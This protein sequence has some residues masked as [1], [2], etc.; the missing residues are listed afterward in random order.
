MECDQS[1]NLCDVG[2]GRI[3]LLYEHED[4]NIPNH[5]LSLPHHDP[6]HRKFR[7]APMLPKPSCK[8]D[9]SITW[10]SRSDDN[11]DIVMKRLNDF[12]EQTKPVI[13]FFEEHNRLIRFVPHQGVDDLPHLVNLMTERIKEE[14]P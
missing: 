10:S 1:F 7:M 6:Q 11:S 3:N 4:V 13:K 8:C 14:E 9:K 12:H 2:E 5:S